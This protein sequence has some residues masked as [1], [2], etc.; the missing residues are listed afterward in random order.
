MPAMFTTIAVE[1]QQYGWDGSP[2]EP[3][4]GHPFSK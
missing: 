2:R 4:Q 3:A 1:H